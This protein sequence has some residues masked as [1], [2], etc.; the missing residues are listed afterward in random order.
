[1]H[2]QLQTE[3]KSLFFLKLKSTVDLRREREI[4]KVRDQIISAGSQSNSFLQGVIMFEIS[5]ST[6]P[7]KLPRVR[8]MSK[9]T[10]RG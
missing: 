9:I 8:K 2:H 7:K 1:M 3:N 10:L 5:P 6:T 4:E